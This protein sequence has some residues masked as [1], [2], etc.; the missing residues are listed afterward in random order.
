ME[1]H[2]RSVVKSIIWRLMGIVILGGVTYGFT[3][4]WIQTTGITFVY[5]GMFLIIYYLHDRLWIVITSKAPSFDKSQIFFRPLTYE[6][7]LG[8]MILGLISLAVTR[9]WITMSLITFT[10]IWNKIWI[11]FV[12]DWIWREKIKWGKQ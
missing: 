8:H 6:L 9:S 10:Y 3:R 4:N 11:Y 12:Y 5:H 7:I 2:K 1:T